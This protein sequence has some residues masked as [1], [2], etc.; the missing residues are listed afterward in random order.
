MNLTIYLS[1]YVII[2]TSIIGY[3]LLFLKIFKNTIDIEFEYNL[4]G[5]LLFLIFLSF[6]THFFLSHGYIH[7]LI[8]L[9]IGII[10]FLLNFS[11]EKKNIRNHIK[12]I[13]IIFGIL[14][15]ALLTHKTHDDFP[16]YHFPY[17]YYL[18]QENLVIGA[19]QLVHAFRTPSSIFYLNS[20][21]Y[22]PIIEYF[23]FNMGAIL[24]LGFSNLILIFKLKNDFKSKRY[25]F[26]FFLTLLSFLFIN[27]FFYRIAE[28]GT[29]RSAQILILILFIEVLNFYRMSIN[30]E[31]IFTKIFILLGLIITLKAFY[32]LYLLILIPI[33]IEIK[34]SRLFLNFLKNFYFYIFCSVG[35]FLILINIFNSG[36]FLYPVAITCFTNFEWSLFYEA[37][38]SNDWYE[39]WAKAGAGPNHRVNDPENYIKGFNWVS[40]WVEMYFFNKV[41]DFI[42]GLVFLLLVVLFTFY[43]KKKTYK[44]IKKQ[45]YYIYLIVLILFF[46]WFYNHPSLRYGGYSLVALIMFMPFSI[47]ISQFISIRFLKEKIVFLIALSLIIFVGR[48]VNRINYEIQTY[49]YK[50]FSYPFYYLD[51]SHFRVDKYFNSMLVNYQNCVKNNEINCES[52]EGLSLSKKNIYYILKRDK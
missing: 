18:T 28:H 40:N 37:K 17:T 14:I 9:F 1:Y 33:L 29:D 39:Q 25:D 43:S 34:K 10:S 44:K 16:Y 23:L 2:I 5:S 45:N 20:L 46:E 51:Q 52:L 30:K 27:I 8:I 13:S 48:N 41:S 35:F 19:G 6:F 26:I 24:I 22:L 47:Y 31:K 36:C 32:V 49:D 11:K 3:G 21:F 38:S 7:N 42:L 50:I 15:I 4:L 12:Y